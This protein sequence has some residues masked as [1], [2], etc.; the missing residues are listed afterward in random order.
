MAEHVFLLS[1]PGLRSQDLAEMPNLKSLVADGDAAPLVPSFPAVTWP[2][3]SNMLTGELANRHGVVANGFYWRDRHEVEM[4]TATNDK[5]QAPQIWDRLHTHDAALTSAAWFPMLSKASNADVI[6][7]PAPI[8]NPDG[9]ESLWC[10]SRPIELYGELRDALGHFPLQNFW[11]PMAN[12][13]STR[14]IAE[15]AAHA[16]RIHQPRFFYVYLPH[17][18]YAAQKNGPDSPEATAACQQLDEVLG[19][20]TES[21]H[22]TYA[23][24]PLWLVASEYVIVPVNHVCYPNRMLRG[25]GFLTC[26]DADG[27][28]E[29]DI[30]S[31]RAWALV[32]H[33][34]SHVY[35]R[36][37]N[38]IGP[39]ADLFRGCEGIAEV[40]VGDQRATWSMDH[41]R[42]GEIVLISEPHSWQAYYWWTDDARAPTYA[43]TVD[44]HRKP[45]Y[46]PVELHW[47]HERRCVPLDA[48]L[49]R[50]SH[51]APARAENQYGVLLSSQKGV[52]VEHPLPDTDVCEIVLRQFGV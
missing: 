34:F 22:A 1:V 43:R 9:S 14:W 33:Q 20:F 46:D 50:G 36:D 32:D 6:C 31:S 28:E 35:V 2:A 25:A 23:E 24:A 45:G 21:I 3:Q 41:E 18:D 51:G 52:F 12:I 49:I 38:D 15:S 29:L 19:A 27:H 7:M 47:D 48:T 42:S 10:Y 16:A 39:V 8:H 4:W 11:G 13:S 37:Q 17:L 26:N 40:L 5:I 44:I 30:P